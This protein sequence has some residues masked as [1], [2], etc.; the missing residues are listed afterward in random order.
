MAASSKSLSE[1]SAPDYQP[2][3][4][5]PTSDQAIAI[6][7][8]L[9]STARRLFLEQGYAR[10]SMHAIATT[11]R[12]SKGTL[13]ARYP[14]KSHL[15]RA[16]VVDRLSAWPRYAP[17]ASKNVDIKTRLLARA[18]YILKGM[19][20]PEIRAFDQLI[21]AETKSFPELE[22]FFYEL[23]YKVIIMEMASELEAEGRGNNEPARNSIAV[24]TIFQ[25]A[26][27]GWIRSEGLF[28]EISDEE[29]EEY[30]GQVVALCLEGRAAW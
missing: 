5:R 2:R 6:D 10:T 9:V 3:R 19:R 16:I 23:G 4:G 20:D 25:Q 14:T 17:S 22:H 1:L 28:R 24:A 18:I 29:C 15:F 21:L 27:H 7:D 30:A 11:A 13:Y 12:V 8:H 26:L